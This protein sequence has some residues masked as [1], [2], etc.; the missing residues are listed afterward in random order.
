MT[1]PRQ[2][3]GLLFLTQGPLSQRPQ[4]PAFVYRHKV[5]TARVEQLSFQA[6]SRRGGSLPHHFHLSKI[7]D[8]H[9]DWKKKVGIN[10]IHFE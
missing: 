6:G 9:L 3:V 8:R 4:P 1:L 2:A 7:K 5:R 10:I